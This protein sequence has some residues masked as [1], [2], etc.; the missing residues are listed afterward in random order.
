MIQFKDDLFCSTDPKHLNTIKLGAKECVQRSGEVRKR[1]TGQFLVICHGDLWNNNILFNSDTQNDESL[2]LRFVDL[3]A[4]ALTRPSLDLCNLIYQNTTPDLRQNH[5]EE[6]LGTYHEELLSSLRLLGHSNPDL[7]PHP[8]FMQ[9]FNDFFV[10]GFMMGLINT[11]V[12]VSAFS[13]NF[14][15]FSLFISIC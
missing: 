7:Y 5:L 3:Q 13:F 2:D 14:L 15:R 10:H 6:I 8:T 9:D 4:S 12:R 1:K 11:Q